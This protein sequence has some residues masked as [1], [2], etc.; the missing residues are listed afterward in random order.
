MQTSWREGDVVQTDV[1]LRA[2]SHFPLK[3]DLEV[4]AVAQR[5]FLHLPEGAL[6]SCE[7]EQKIQVSFTF[8]E[9]TE[10]SNAVS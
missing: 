4:A 1:P 7:V 2:F 10:C 5:D 3:L 9:D 8:P 6:V